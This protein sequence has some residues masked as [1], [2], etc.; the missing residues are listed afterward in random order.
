VNTLFQK[1]VA[2]TGISE[3]F[4]EHAVARACERAGIDPHRLSPTNL[5][6]ALPEIEKIVRTFC[7]DEMEEI[8]PRLYSLTRH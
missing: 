5:K 6:I 1:V 8:M 4:A 2:A 7:H 3:L